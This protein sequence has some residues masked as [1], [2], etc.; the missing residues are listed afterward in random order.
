MSAISQPKI[1]GVIFDLDETII[2]SLEAYTAAF[3]TGTSIFGLET[4]TSKRIA[5]YLDKGFRLGDILIT[6]FPLVFKDDSKRQECHDEILKAYLTMETEKVRLKHGAECTL[7]WLKAEGFKIG[8][9]TGRTTMGDS[10]WRELRRLNIHQFV[11]VMVTGAEAPPKPAPDGLIKCLE[12]LGLAP[13]ECLFVGDSSVDVIAGKKA[14]VRTA[15]VHTGVA[16][17]KLLTEQKPDFVIDDLS[18][19]LSCLSETQKPRRNKVGK[20]KE[21]FAFAAKAGSLEG[22]LYER[23]Q[24]EPLQNWISNIEK[25]YTA[26]PDNVKKEIK[27]EFSTVLKRILDYGGKALDR[28]LKAKLNGLLPAR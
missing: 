16:N 23:Q 10:K 6:F 28:E 12:E 27:D 8:I 20:Y 22:Y 11:D 19:L 17:K 1:K 7:R 4:V 15:S 26:L 25:M 14:G 2:D 18:S 24:V 21:L 9:V 3:N 13:D 5:R